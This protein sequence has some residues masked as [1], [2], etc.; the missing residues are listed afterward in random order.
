MIRSSLFSGWVL[1]IAISACAAQQPV[2]VTAAQVSQWLERNRGEKDAKLARR[3]ST[4]ELTERADAATLARWQAESPGR[5]SR[6]ALA[7]LAGRAVFLDPPPSNMLGKPR[8][9]RWEL[10]RILLLASAYVK[11]TVPR[12]PDFY[13]QRTTTYFVATP[14]RAPNWPGYCKSSKRPALGSGCFA[15][16]STVAYPRR[17]GIDPLRLAGESSEIVTYRNGAEVLSNQSADPRLPLEFL[18]LATNGEFGPIL[19]LVL[20]DALQG[21]VAWGYWE[22]GRKQ[23]L[24]VIRYRVPKGSSHYVVD[25]PFPLSLEQI[26]PAYH[27][28]IAI[29]PATGTIWRITLVDDPNPQRQNLATSLMLQYGPVII[30][31]KPYACPIRGVAWSKEPVFSRRKGKT[32]QLPFTQTRLDE[33]RF[34][35]YHQ[36][37]GDVKVVPPAAASASASP[38]PL[39][40]R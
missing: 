26:R 31:G 1:A 14:L 23:P 34:T 20:D 17:P 15:L 37:R 16:G 38:A 11:R 35:G 33:F 6:V 19:S 28:E 30:G 25:Y 39:P 5:Q 3:L 4:L 22:Q 27:G 29:D 12:L 36:F 2:R 8:P 13:A 7:G 21:E 40:P 10:Q 9:D 32:V 18:D 24:A